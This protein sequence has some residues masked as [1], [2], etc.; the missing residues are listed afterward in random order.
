MI[1]ALQAGLLPSEANGV[2]GDIPLPIGR[3]VLADPSY[4]FAK[5]TGAP[6]PMLWVSLDRVKDLSG[7]VARLLRVFPKSGLWP[8]AL[9]S[10]SSS[11]SRPWLDGEL[12]PSGSS[13]PASHDPRT[14]L[15]EWWD[16][17]I[18]EE[19]EEAE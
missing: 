12:D 3:R 8:L 4:S 11:D 14:V 5:G 17:A 13:S 10:L 2:V 16:G 9:E 6:S 1:S 19:G 18:P 7:L 15:A